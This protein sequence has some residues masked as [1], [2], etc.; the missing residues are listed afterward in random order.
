MRSTASLGRNFYYYCYRKR[1][2]VYNFETI[3]PVFIRTF[4]SC[5]GEYYQPPTS[6]EPFFLFTMCTVTFSI[7]TD[8]DICAYMYR[9]GKQTDKSFQVSN[10]LAAWKDF[11]SVLVDG[12]FQSF[13]TLRNLRTFGI[14][15]SHKDESNIINFSLFLISHSQE[16]RK[17]YVQSGKKNL[18][19]NPC[20]SL[21]NSTS[22]IWIL[23]LKVSFFLDCI[24]VVRKV[25]LFQGT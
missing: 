7:N 12:V 10:L 19:G 11:E 23:R 17:S 5:F 22:L 25:K 21:I 16:D 6:C 24:L 2:I 4:F 15:N 1:K 18:A 13:H 20:P 3:R 14:E 8:R 9:L